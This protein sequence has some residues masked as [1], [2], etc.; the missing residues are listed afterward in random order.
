M[1]T[2]R[3]EKRNLPGFRAKAEP[4]GIIIT[5]QFPVLSVLQTVFSLHVAINLVMWILIPFYKR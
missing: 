3:T 2:K 1:A 5:T 4:Y